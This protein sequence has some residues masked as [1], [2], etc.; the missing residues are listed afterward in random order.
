[1]SEPVLSIRG[2][3]ARYGDFQA[4]FDVSF[5][6]MPGSTLALI[7]ANGAGKSTLLKTI[8]G[9][10]R[11]EPGMVIYRGERIG[12][13]DASKIVRRGIGLVPEGR[14]LF[15]SL[16]VEE[17]L[18]IGRVRGRGGDWDIERVYRLFPILRDKRK[19]LATMLSGGQQ[20]MV[21]IS[22]TL[23]GNPDVI[24]LDEISLGLAPVVIKAI[25]HALPEIIGSGVSAVV[26]EQDIARALSVARSVV[27][28]QKGRISLTGRPEDFSRGDIISAYFGT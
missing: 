15:P 18:L 24:L 19:S 5:D 25:Y 27:C 13:I 9:L 14:Q 3:R 8:V 22:R 2:L 4:L 10:L 28:L 20:Q 12:G 16:S 11:C 1:M 17:N 6:L 21:A 7:G 26:V 23:M